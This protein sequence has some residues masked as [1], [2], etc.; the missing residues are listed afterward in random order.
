MN[1]FTSLLLANGGYNERLVRSGIVAQTWYEGQKK[2]GSGRGKNL[3]PYRGERRKIPSDPVPPALQLR[4]Q[5][6]STESSAREKRMLSDTGIT[7]A[8][9]LVTSFQLLSAGALLLS[10]AAILMGHRRDLRATVRQSAVTDQLANDLSRI[11]SALER[12]AAQASDSVIGVASR[13]AAARRAEARAEVAAA[14]AQAAEARVASEPAGDEAHRVA[15][16]I[17]G[18]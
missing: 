6:E 13:A 12:I 10:V 2:R 1:M 5:S 18:R 16:S 4:A 8:G 14:E 9:H 17:F 3:L 15:Y 7:V 11:A